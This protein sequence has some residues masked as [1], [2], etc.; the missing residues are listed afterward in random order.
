MDLEEGYCGACKDWT[1][2]LAAAKLRAA[3]D[4]L[5]AQTEPTEFA[6]FRLFGTWPPSGET[7]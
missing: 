2:N 1:G 5:T 6:Y 7:P 4:A 3:V